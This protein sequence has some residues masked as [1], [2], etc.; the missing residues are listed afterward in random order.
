MTSSPCVSF[1]RS[2]L[3]VPG[4]SPYQLIP[5]YCLSQRNSS[6]GNLHHI[7]TCHQSSTAPLSVPKL[8]WN[9]LVIS[10]NLCVGGNSESLLQQ[11]FVPPGHHA[12]TRINDR[13]LGLRNLE[14]HCDLSNS[15]TATHVSP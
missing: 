8:N 11:L 13:I 9:C 10:F 1:G 12:V 14:K 4:S 6:T 5:C 7:N 15:G 2:A 3:Q